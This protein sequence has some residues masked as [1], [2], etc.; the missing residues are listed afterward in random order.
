[1]RLGDASD[2]G[3]GGMWLDPARSGLYLVWRRPLP[4]DI[5]IDLV[6]LTNME[7]KIA[8]SDLELAA[9][10]LHEATLLVSVSTAHMS[11][12]RYGSD[13]TP[14]ILWSIH[15]ALTINPVVVDLLHIRAL[16]SRIFFLNPSIFY[17]PG[18]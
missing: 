12:P 9:L 1:M 10:V 2:L 14:T 5:I 17:H 4:P 3:A 16:C 8:N 7:V 13:N 15:E 18:Q 6:S 11:T